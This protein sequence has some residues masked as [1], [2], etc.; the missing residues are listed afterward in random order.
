ML[1]SVE[2][3][4]SVWN[5][6]PIGVLH[7]GAHNAEESEDYKSFNWGNIFWIEAQK[8]LINSIKKD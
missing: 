3:L 2:T 8:D 5:I 4:S 6:H 1:F 7:V